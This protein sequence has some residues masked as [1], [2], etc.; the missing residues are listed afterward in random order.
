MKLAYLVNRYPSIS[1]SF[2]RREI[3]ALERR[4]AEIIPLFNPHLRTGIDRR[5]RPPRGGKDATHRRREPA[6]SCGRNC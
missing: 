4:G 6:L 5:G 1:H 2:I 3:E